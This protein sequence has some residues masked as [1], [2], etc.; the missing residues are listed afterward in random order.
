VL[1]SFGY[2]LYEENREAVSRKINER[3]KTSKL[4]N[5]IEEA[6]QYPFGIASGIIIWHM[7]SNTEKRFSIVSISINMCARTASR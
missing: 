6:L 2:I 5:A 1:P 3:H 4:F 7:S